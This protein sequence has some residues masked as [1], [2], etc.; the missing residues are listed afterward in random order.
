MC[1]C[2]C[3]CVRSPTVI[4]KHTRTLWIVSLGSENSDVYF[5]HS[6]QTCLIRKT[7]QTH[8]VGQGNQPKAAG[9]NKVNL[10]QTTATAETGENGRFDP[11]PHQQL[12]QIG[13]ENLFSWSTLPQ[14]NMPITNRLQTIWKLSGRICASHMQVQLL[15]TFP[16]GKDFSAVS[17][18][19]WVTDS[20]PDLSCFCR[21]S[22]EEKTNLR[23]KE[24]QPHSSYTT[25]TH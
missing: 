18:M 19:A 13:C 4:H 5:K 23:L 15:K 8:T 24:L 2:V 22:L 1:A 21:P 14:T 11:N 9:K 3:V 7:P 10:G 20:L 12:L 6:K 25:S 16:S 17:L